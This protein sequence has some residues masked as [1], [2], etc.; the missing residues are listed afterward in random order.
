L[1]VTAAYTLTRSSFQHS[2]QSDFAGWGQVM[3]GDELPY[4]PHHQVALQATLVAPRWEVSA[5]G[6]WRGAA[7]DLP[8]QGEM[9][10]GERIPSLLTLDV[11]AHARLRAYAELYV[12][13]SNLL[14]EQAIVAR[15][16]YG[17]RPNAP[18]LIAVGY[19]ARF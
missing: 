2:F 10:A 4:L 15:R 5:G 14:D 7:R 6:S 17:V 18:R 16:P 9:P 8:G 19:K 3:K 12:T 1:P 11:T 13:C